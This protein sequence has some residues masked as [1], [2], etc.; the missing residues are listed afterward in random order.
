MHTETSPGYFDGIVHTMTYSGLDVVFLQI[1]ECVRAL[2]DSTLQ[3]FL[4]QFKH[5]I[6]K[7]DK[8]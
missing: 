4:Q 1:G 7:I 2:Q 6:N 3:M 5:L 8:K